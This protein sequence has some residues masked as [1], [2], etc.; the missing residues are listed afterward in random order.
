[1]KVRTLFLFTLLSVMSFSCKK[2]VVQADDYFPNEVGYHW[3]YRWLNDATVGTIE[4]KIV[5]S[6]PLSGGQ[7]AKVWR[8]TYNNGSNIYI[9]TLWVI[10]TNNEV[11]IYNNFCLSDSSQMPYERLHYF[12]PLENGR[13][14]FTNVPQGDT[15][16]VLNHETVSVPAG[17]FDDVY[18]ISK[19]V[20]YATNAGVNDTLYFKEHIGLVKFFQHD[21]QLG[22]VLGN[23]VW[24]LTDYNF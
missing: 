24:E 23:G 13:Q 17:T 20:G 11:S 12:F 9:D 8:Y 19:D 15:T 5:D 4:V 14:W 18:R 22:P 21:F 7:E 1:M 2:E 16:K 3:T 10:S 6:K